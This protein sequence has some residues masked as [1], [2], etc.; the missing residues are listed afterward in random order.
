MFLSAQELYIKG[1]DLGDEGVKTLCE[2]LKSHKGAPGLGVWHSLVWSS[3]GLEEGE[4]AVEGAHGPQ[5]CTRLAGL[6]R[7][8]IG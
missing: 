6:C 7:W 8:L 1:N 2:A 3:W 4:D 5:G